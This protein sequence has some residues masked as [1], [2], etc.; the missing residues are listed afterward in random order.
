MKYT[1]GAKATSLVAAGIV[2]V[3]LMLT[4]SVS[5]AAPAA[6]PKATGGVELSAPMQYLEFNA[7]DYGAPA[8]DRGSVAYTNFTK[9]EPGT[10]V[11]MLSDEVDFVL[12]FTDPGIGER[13]HTM[14][15]TSVTPLSAH[16]IAFTGTGYNNGY[17]GTYDWSAHG[18]VDSSVSPAEFSMDFVY[19]S[20]LAG[21]GGHLD[22]TI[23]AGVIS[24]DFT[25]DWGDGTWSATSAY[26]VFSYT[27]QPNCVTVSS[28]THKAAFSYVIPAGVSLAGTPVLWVMTD[29][30]S[31]GAVYD[32][33]GFTTAFT[34]CDPT[35]SVPAS[36]IVAGNLVV[37]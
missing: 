34:G 17:Q 1:R 10:G 29:L 30:G 28:S 8:N 19:T 31:P 35:T 37:H 25:S 26:E 4:V 23:T 2:G 3:V 5:A 21:M 16:K 13:D 18:I 12:Q 7:F 27:T 22:G 32:T 14:N 36:T 11:W 24:G 6:T 33:L 9:A 20:Q 15:V